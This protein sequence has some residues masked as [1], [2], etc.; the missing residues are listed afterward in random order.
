MEIGRHR[1]GQVAERAQD[2]ITRGGH[3]VFDASTTVG[4]IKRTFDDLVGYLYRELS[5]PTGCYLFTGTG[6]VPPD[7]FSLV[8]G[9]EVRITIEPIGTLTN[10]VL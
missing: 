1:F 6:I 9:D 5:F 4:M 8:A 10:V 3:V 7:D 2:R